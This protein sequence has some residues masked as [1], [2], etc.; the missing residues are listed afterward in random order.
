MIKI[1]KRRR[2]DTRLHV[3][4]GPGVTLQK[5]LGTISSFS[6]NT[7]TGTSLSCIDGRS[8]IAVI[9]LYSLF[10]KGY[11]YNCCHV[12]IARMDLWFSC[13]VISHHAT[14]WLVYNVLRVYGF[15]IHWIAIIEKIVLTLSTLW[16]NACCVC[17]FR[18]CVIYSVKFVMCHEWCM[19][20]GVM[21][22]AVLCRRWCDAL[23]DVV[24][25]VG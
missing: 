19:G 4:C 14:R 11:Y 16:C 10:K 18:W 21:S 22:S 25:V 6:R 8:S 1:D 7:S 13:S 3:Q 2:D 20:S 15:S 17:V 23:C 24:W 5:I 12:I 9:L